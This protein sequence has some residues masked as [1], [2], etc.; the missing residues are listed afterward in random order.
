MQGTP[1]S[2]KNAPIEHDLSH[3]MSLLEEVK[4]LSRMLLTFITTRNCSQI[5]FMSC[6]MLLVAVIAESM[7]MTNRNLQR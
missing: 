4:F 2:N 7:E 1:D 6:G 3:K 5:G